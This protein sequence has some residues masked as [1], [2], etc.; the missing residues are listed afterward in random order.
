[1]PVFSAY[2]MLVK[3]IDPAS[4]LYR[5]PAHPLSVQHVEV[6]DVV[7]DQAEGGVV[8]LGGECE[9][10]EVGGGAGGVGIGIG[11]PLA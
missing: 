8:D 2:G 5:I 3:D 10:V 4:L 1:V 7:V 9:R 6:A 11:T